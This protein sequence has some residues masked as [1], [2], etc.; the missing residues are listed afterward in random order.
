V[1][2]RG[3]NSRNQTGNRLNS[4]P[5]KTLQP[6]TG[7]KPGAIRRSIKLELISPGGVT[8]LTIETQKSILEMI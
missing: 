2:Q 5:L 8:Y 1:L 6:I 3:D 4:F 7:L